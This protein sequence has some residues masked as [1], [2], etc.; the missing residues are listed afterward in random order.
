MRVFR[1]SNWT[2]GLV[3][4]AALLVQGCVQQQ[5]AA[6]PTV[7]KP[8]VGSSQTAQATSA[9]YASIRKDEGH[10]AAFGCSE[11]F[12]TTLQNGL[13]ALRNKPGDSHYLEFRVRV[14]P[15]IPSG[16]MHVVYGELDEKMVP[17]TFNYV[18]LLPKGSVFGLYAGIFVPV[19][20]SGQ[21]EPSA[22]DCAIK[23]T[24]AFRMS[25]S[26]EEYQKVLKRIERF[27]ANTP[28]WRM[29]SYNCNHF[30]ADI[31][32]LVGLKPVQGLRSNQF[33]SLSYFDRYMRT[34]GII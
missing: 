6:V 19:G 18:G 24:R 7:A 10:V 2:I 26:T 20:I 30:A 17:K 27:R 4:A 33:L 31:G 13:V 3:C 28:E 1:R 9:T 16:H 23:P 14:S 12:V 8:A 5:Q 34:N 29:L 21:L 22:M 15:A 11:N 25:I 32:S